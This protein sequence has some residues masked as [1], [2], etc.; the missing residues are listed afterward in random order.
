MVIEPHERYTSRGF[1]EGLMAVE[2]DE[3]WGYI[4]RNEQWVIPPQYLDAE[5]FSEGLA[6]VEREDGN[7]CYIN[8]QGK[9]VIQ[10]G[11][12]EI[13]RSWIY[14]PAHEFSQGLAAVL[15]P[16]TDSFGFINQQ[17]DWVIQPQL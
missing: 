15:D 6:A 3:R 8:P 9:E 7:W 10:L 5:S 17:G 2:E 4:N 1:H 13:T 12:L 14:T 16:H 11:E